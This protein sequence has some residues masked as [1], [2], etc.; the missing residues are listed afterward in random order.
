MLGL[1]AL[2][3]RLALNRA[4]EGR[5]DLSTGKDDAAAP[6]VAA[7][8]ARL[9]IGIDRDPPGR[10]DV[11]V[12]ASRLPAGVRLGRLAFSPALQAMLTVGGGPPGLF[13]L[14]DTRG[15]LIAFFAG[16][17]GLGSGGDDAGIAPEVEAALQRFYG[18]SIGD[19]AADCLA[20][21]DRDDAVYTLLLS[22][23]FDLAIARMPGLGAPHPRYPRL[24]RGLLDALLILAELE[25][26]RDIVAALAGDLASGPPAVYRKMPTSRDCVRLLLGEEPTAVWD[27]AAMD[28]FLADTPFH[29]ETLLWQVAAGPR[30]IEPGDDLLAMLA[31]R[32]GTA[33][34]LRFPEGRKRLAGMLK[35][36][37]AMR[38]NAAGKVMPT[39]LARYMGLD[40]LDTATV[41][42]V[43]MASGT[44]RLGND[45]S[46]RMT[47]LA[48][49]WT[50]LMALVTSVAPDV[51]QEAD[52]RFL[53]GPARSFDHAV[54]DI[55]KGEARLRRASEPDGLIHAYLP[56]AD[57][58]IGAGRF[59]PAHWLGRN[60]HHAWGRSIVRDFRG[61]AHRG[62]IDALPA[63]WKPA[64]LVRISA[65]RR[66]LRQI[67]EQVGARGEG[68]EDLA[69]TTLVVL[70]CAV[71]PLSSDPLLHFVLERHR[72]QRSG[73]WLGDRVRALRTVGAE[74][75]VALDRNYSGHT[76]DEA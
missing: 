18:L 36:A 40:L 71:T 76:A 29:V 56:P 12:S 26:L 58:P 54:A 52:R 14:P 6:D 1:P 34:A 11:G 30:S 23:E 49:F 32:Q 74:Q 27:D 41:G 19:V 61:G 73:D 75:D 57:T 67:E 46:D 72:R 68:N 7:L 5:P 53:R 64:I 69:A 35:D 33:A 60:H 66:T 65:L 31:G 42:L 48:A 62:M 15:A 63:P 17:T 13:R 3:E 55:D 16:R 51:A 43:E 45:R 39:T 38:P 70:L 22:L 21:R 28:A 9:A 25:R 4:S 50:L 47:R 20:V 59:V 37:R 44:A 8:A 2:I 24:A 10:E